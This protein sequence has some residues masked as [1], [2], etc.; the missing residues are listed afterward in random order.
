MATE[1]GKYMSLRAVVA[2]FLSEADKSHYDSDR[3]WLLG[4]RGL[5][6]VNRT[7]AAMPKTVRIPVSGNKTC[8]FPPDCISWTKIGILNE[9]GEISTLRINTGLTTFRDANPNRLTQLTP[10][11]NDSIGNLV[12]SPF[13][14]NYY[15][16]DT[17]N[18]LF[19]IAGGLIQY[20]SCTV[21]EENELVVLEPT[22]RYDAIM[23]EYISNPSKDGDFQVETVLIEPIIAFIKAKLK[24]GTMEEFYAECTDSRRSLGGKRV[25]LQG[26]NQVIRESEA[27][28]VRS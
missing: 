1:I 3:C 13:Y 28:K 22:F 6:K 11:I 15:Y 24:L 2:A 18:T 23:F 25:T 8:P 26:I 27:Q 14:F 12:C 5:L 20:G 9:A 19:G 21:D 4:M 16:G 10:D 17:Y 7:F